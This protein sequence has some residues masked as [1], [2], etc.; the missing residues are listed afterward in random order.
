MRVVII[1]NGAIDGPNHRC[2]Y[3]RMVRPIVLESCLNFACDAF[4][5]LVNN[6]RLTRLCYKFACD[7]F[8]RLV[9]NTRLTRLCYN[10]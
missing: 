8:T 7:A 2:T 5:R 1:E 3:I 6:T 9:N 10:L 4:T